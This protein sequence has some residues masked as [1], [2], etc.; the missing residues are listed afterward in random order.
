[1]IL[2][3]E[4]LAQVTRLLVERGRQV[5]GADLVDAVRT[6]HIVGR[7]ARAFFED[8]D[9]L[10][11]PALG[12]VPPELGVFNAN[13][14]DFDSYVGAVIGFTPFTMTWNATGQPAISLPL[15]QTSTGF[16]IG[17]QFVARFGDEA[18]L[19]RLAAQLEQAAPWAD[20]RPAPLG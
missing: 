9:V 14:E 12:Q 2:G 13:T 20:R 18:T 10:I 8:H 17:V 5:S 19:F 1:M 16:P 4:P 3:Q 11:T 15:S 6:A 7:Q